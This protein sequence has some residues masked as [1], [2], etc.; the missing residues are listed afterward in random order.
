MS[1]ASELSQGSAAIPEQQDVCIA[2][3]AVTKLIAKLLEKIGVRKSKSLELQSLL[4]D[5]VSIMADIYF[6]V[7]DEIKL[8]DP[9]LEF[10]FSLSDMVMSLYT[11][12]SGTKVFG[13]LSFI[14]KLLSQLFHLLRLLVQSNQALKEQLANTKIAPKISDFI[15]RTKEIMKTTESLLLDEI[16]LVIQLNDVLQG[17]SVVTDFSYKSQV[18]SIVAYP[19]NPAFLGP[20]VRSLRKLWPEYSGDPFPATIE[21]AF[22]PPPIVTRNFVELST[23]EVRK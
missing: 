22:V 11:T 9:T 2:L 4:S 5:H 12:L 19:E 13:V 6:T 1:V 17:Q 23:I 8:I 15:S 3:D 14:L 20:I 18:L 21:Y 16:D 10:D 7:M